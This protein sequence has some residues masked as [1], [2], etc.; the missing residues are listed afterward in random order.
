[1]SRNESTELDRMKANEL[2]RDMPT[3]QTYEFVQPKNPKAELNLAAL[4]CRY[5]VESLPYE[6]FFLCVTTWAVTLSVLESQPKYRFTTFFEQEAAISAL[7]TIDLILRLCSYS[8]KRNSK[9]LYI[10]FDIVIVVL[11]WLSLAQS[12]SEDFRFLRVIRV[13]RILH[14]LQLPHLRKDMETIAYGL[15]LAWKPV[16]LLFTITV[17]YL[18]VIGTVGYY[19]EQTGCYYAF[20]APEGIDRW[21][22]SGNYPALG[23]T[24]G[25]PTR[26]QSIA[27]TM[28][29]AV[30]TFYTQGYG[31]TYPLTMA[32]KIAMWFGIVAA[33]VL[34]VVPLGLFG[35]KMS[36]SYTRSTSISLRKVHMALH[37]DKDYQNRLLLLN[38]HLTRVAERSHEFAR[39]AEA[40]LVTVDSCR[41]HLAVLQNPTGC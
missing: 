21:L 37:L 12:S 41:A 25:T 7:F 20:Y 5:T 29:F 35:E 16:L 18:F 17:I 10:Y 38:D 27:Q 3:S 40:A 24:P 4:L 6:L 15:Y 26:W 22:Y 8:P 36:Q 31:D 19:G 28:W 33:A 30:V 11:G 34:I 1:M 39:L 9:D 13:I 32:S 23:F 14:I 2:F